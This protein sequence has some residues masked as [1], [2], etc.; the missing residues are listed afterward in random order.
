MKLPQLSISRPVSVVMFYIAVVLL[1]VISLSR[2]PQELFPPITYPQLT[3]VTIYPNAAPEEVENQ[4]SKP[5]EEGV[6][7]VGGLNR[8]LSKSKE[9]L[10][11]VMAQFG[12]NQDMDLASLSLREKVDLIKARIPSEASEPIVMK[13]NPFELPILKLSVTSEEL[14]LYRLKKNM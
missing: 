14:D 5:I 13:F 6:G 3:V 7:T 9:G 1:G 2:L 8:V 11:L 12:W 4:I 10:S